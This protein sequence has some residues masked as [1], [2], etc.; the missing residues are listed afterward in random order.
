MPSRILHELSRHLASLLEERLTEKPAAPGGGA[1]AARPAAGRDRFR[2]YLSHPLDS[3]EG[4]DL[5]ARTI[6]I[7]YPFRV[8]PDARFRRPGLAIEP[9]DAGER[10]R[11]NPLWLRVRYA[12]L[13]AGGA[14]ESQL[15]A[16]EDALRTIHDH[17]AVPAT[18]LGLPAGTHP[19]E[20]EA[21]YPLRIVEDT[22]A[23]REL[24]LTEHR[25]LILF[26]VTVPIESWRSE[27]FERILDRE[28]V[29]EEGTR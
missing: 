3:F 22:E 17:A 14:L 16:V 29:I 21:S 2:V 13:V 19:D 24:G 15:G 8:G 25:L 1:P 20:E 6:G 18:V 11:W 9:A 26:E 4:E 7:L 27:P 23:W 12:F 28:V 5:A 10:L